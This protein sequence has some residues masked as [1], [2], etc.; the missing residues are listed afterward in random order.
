MVVS[1]MDD[2]GEDDRGVLDRA[3]A[4]GTFDW[5]DVS[6][7][8]GGAKQAGL[9]DPELIRAAALGLI[10]EGLC[11]GL[12]VAG[13]ADKAGFHPWEGTPGLVV[14]RIVHEWSL[15]E[16][17]PTPGNPAWFELTESGLERGRVSQTR[18]RA[19]GKK[20]GM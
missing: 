18:W 7:F 14:E 12:F 8:S 11:T 17:Y 10:A 20:D 4:S 1:V 6:E 9:E 16:L 2:G 13:S 3:L 19:P 15:D 5:I